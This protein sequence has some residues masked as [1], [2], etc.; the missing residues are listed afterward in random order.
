MFEQQ[1]NK[2]TTFQPDSEMAS[3]IFRN[4]EALHGTITV[5]LLTHTSILLE[6]VLGSSTQLSRFFL[7]VLQEITYS[8]KT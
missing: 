6:N 1:F 4:G 8:T 3:S 7:Y 5:S 2:S